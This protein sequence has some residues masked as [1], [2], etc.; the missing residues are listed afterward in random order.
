MGPGLV[1]SIAGALLGHHSGKVTITQMKCPPGE[2][3]NALETSF[4]LSD[5]SWRAGGRG[6]ALF[7]N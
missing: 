3:A 7:S 5:Y 4:S 2:P 6:K 1:A